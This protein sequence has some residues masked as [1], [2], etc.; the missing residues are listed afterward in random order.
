MRIY[1]VVGLQRPLT[2]RVEAQDIKGKKFGIN[3]KD[4]QARIFQHEYDHLEVRTLRLL[5]R[6]KVPSSRCF[7]HCVLHGVG[8]HLR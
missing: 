8:R 1:Q 4:F 3:L 5:G 7:I 6:G 2:V